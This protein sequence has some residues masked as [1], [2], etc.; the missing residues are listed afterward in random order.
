MALTAS[1]DPNERSIGPVI[2]TGINLHDDNLNVVAR[3]VL[4]QPI[5]KRSEDRY[6]FRIK[7][8]W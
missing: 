6:L 4:A 5:I 1:D 2:I 3:A 8:D 7:M